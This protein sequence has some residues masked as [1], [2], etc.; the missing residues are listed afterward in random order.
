M[1]SNS[2]S[3]EDELKTLDKKCKLLLTG[4]WISLVL[5]GVGTVVTALTNQA[6]FAAT[7]LTCSLFL[8]ILSRSHQD[9]RIYDQSSQN[10]IEIQRQY[11]SKLQGLR[12]EFLGMD[13][14]EE[15]AELFGVAHVLPLFS[16]RAPFVTMMR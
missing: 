7:P 8:N 12:S 1:K 4:E 3:L 13:F 6:V 16:R 2:I 15:G 14:P 11:A 10:L 9:K 5:S